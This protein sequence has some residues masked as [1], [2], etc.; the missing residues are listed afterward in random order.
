LQ[1]NLGKL[2]AMTH[3]PVAL[4]Y[5]TCPLKM[6]IYLA[7]FFACFLNFAHSFLAAFAIAALP[8]ADNTRFFT[9]N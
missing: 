3:A 6:P 4:M 7:T 1:D 9:P 8:A 5:L 2:N